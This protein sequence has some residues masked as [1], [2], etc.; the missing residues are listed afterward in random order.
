MVFMTV[1][2]FQNGVE[3]NFESVASHEGVS[4]SIPLKRYMLLPELYFAQ[5]IRF[6]IS[7]KV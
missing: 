5:K 3:N 4:N 7:T 6:D 1:A 2:L